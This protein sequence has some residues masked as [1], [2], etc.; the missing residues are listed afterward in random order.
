MSD[1]RSCN[2]SLAAINVAALIE[3]GSTLGSSDASNTRAWT[4]ALLVKMMGLV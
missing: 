2:S 4:I 1:V 3:L